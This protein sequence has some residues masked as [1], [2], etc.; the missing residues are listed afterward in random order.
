LKLK[1][2]NRILAILKSI[3][4]EYDDNSLRNSSYS[5][6]CSHLNGHIRSWSED[7]IIQI[8]TYAKE[9]NMNGKNSRVI[10]LLVQG[11]IN[12]VGMKRLKMMPEIVNI[13]STLLSYGERHFNRLNKL[14]E[15]LYLVEYVCSEATMN[16]II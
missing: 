6:G 9:W 5:L 14:Q 2:P 16:D 3:V 12:V 15:A 10:G 7:D 8:M 1:Y 11:V 13:V 4:D